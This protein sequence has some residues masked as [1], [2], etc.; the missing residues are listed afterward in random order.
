MTLSSDHEI[1][2][3]RRWSAKRKIAVCVLSLPLLAYAPGFVMALPE[4]VAPSL[5]FWAEAPDYTCSS[6]QARS[7]MVRV[8]PYGADRVAPAKNAAGEWGCSRIKSFAAS[9]VKGAH[10]RQPDSGQRYV[11]VYTPSQ[12]QRAR[13]A[14]VRTPDDMS[15]RV[16]SLRPAEPTRSASAATAPKL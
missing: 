11:R 2:S 9:D 8:L 4:G 7:L 5:P 3:G 14:D 16:V 13:L 15:S 12:A 6:T 1:V 10:A